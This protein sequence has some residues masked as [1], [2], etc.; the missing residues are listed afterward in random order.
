MIS[1]VVV[2]HNMLA[3][4]QRC[5]TS[6]LDNTDIEAG[7]TI[8][9]SGSTDGTPDWLRTLTTSGMISR[10]NVKGFD[11][12]IGAA[13]GYNVGFK[14]ADTATVVRIDSD[15]LVPPGWASVLVKGLYSIDRLG[16]LS[17]VMRPPQ[18]DA[19]IG[20]GLGNVVIC[21]DP[22]WH[23]RGIGSWC[24]AIRREVFESVGFYRDLYGPYALQDNDLE[25]QA[26]RSGWLIGHTERIR[27]GHLW[28]RDTP[29][30]V[31][32]TDWKFEEQRKAIEIWK[33]TW[34]DERN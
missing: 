12:N 20:V 26:Q 28:R 8:V 27:V 24:M 10:L 21:E 30:E 7:L 5:I 11:T 31:A 34:G 15:V 29:E 18:D 2:T 22:V 6:I 32:Y 4:T 9:D 33:A 25:K 1:I 13:L 3:Y 17:T 19:P 23:D 16:M 14:A